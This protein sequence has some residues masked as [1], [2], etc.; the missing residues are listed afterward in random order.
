MLASYDPSNGRKLG[1][2]RVSTAAD[3]KAAVARARKA[4]VGWAS[5]GVDG[6]GAI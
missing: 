2:V 4:Q 5:M 1:E 6:L 3:V